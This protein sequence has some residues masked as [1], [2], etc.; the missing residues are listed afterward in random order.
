MGLQVDIA[1]VTVLIMTLLTKSP[2]PPSKPMA[3]VQAS[4]PRSESSPTKGRGLVPEEPLGV[5][6]KVRPGLGVEDCV[7][8]TIKKPVLFYLSGFTRARSLG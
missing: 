3:H 6:I 5:S 8:K 1:V 7:M 4:L 2:G